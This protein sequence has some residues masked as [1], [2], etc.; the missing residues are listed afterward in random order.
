MLCLQNGT[1]NP[2]V[3]GSTPY[4]GLFQVLAD[5]DYMDFR[6]VSVAP[7]V[8][9]YLS[10]NRKGYIL[11]CGY[12]PKQS[13]EGRNIPFITAAGYSTSGFVVKPQ[14]TI[15]Y[16]LTKIFVFAGRRSFGHLFRTALPTGSEGKQQN[17]ICT[18]MTSL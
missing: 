2:S 3:E 8:L 6:K 10:L 7:S 14:I 12:K 4:A 11:G 16:Y 17:I 5:W 9:G 13:E 1:I 18:A 15:D